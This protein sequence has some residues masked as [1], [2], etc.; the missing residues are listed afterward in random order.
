MREKTEKLYKDPRGKVL[1]SF[2]VDLAFMTFVLLCFTA[3]YETNDDV[4]MSKFVDGQMGE[5]SAFIPFVNIILGF[6]LKGLYSITDSFNWYS[7]AQYLTMFLGFWAIGWVLMKRLRPLPAFTALAAILFT[8]GSNAYLYVNFSKTC[9]VAAAGGLSLMLQSRDPRQQGSRSALILGMALALLG[10]MWR[11]EEFF[12]LGAV[13]APLGLV[14]MGELL[15][16]NKGLDIKNRLFS[17][18][19]Y[20]LP[21]LLLLALVGAC[22]GLD[23]WSWNRGEMKAFFQYSNTRSYLMDNSILPE[24]Q[25]MP[26]LYEELGINETASEMLKDWNFFD[27]EVFSQQQ[28]EALRQSRDERVAKPSAGECLG[29]FLDKVIPGLAATLAFWAAAL[30]LLLWLACGRRR[31]Y[32]WMG[33][34]GSF[35]MFGLVYLFMI[36]QNRYLANRVDMGLLLA[37][38]LVMAFLLDEEKLKN[39]RLFCALLMALAVFVG[40]YKNKNICPY[41]DQYTVEDKSFQKAAVERI[42]EDEEHLYLCKVWSMDH[43]IYGPLEKAPKGFADRIVLSG[44]WSM[45]HPSITHVLQSW[46]I[47]NPYEDM[48]GNEGVYLIDKD[49]EQTLDYIHAYYDEDARAVEVQPLSQETGLKIYS[50]LD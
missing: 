27:T 49:I 11:I 17:L 10:F 9:A 47:V 20:A 30:M 5:K 31:W 32:C 12:A 23:L 34:G 28:M 41:T 46:G 48:I 43:Q 33:L 6:A 50:I 35:A 38:A 1:L 21:F 18:L 37:L 25:E 14:A 29:L 42:L 2:A 16:E 7:F 15:A 3:R 39:D 4:L 45:Y 40:L 24:Y 36:F 44:G 19:R 26:E 8:V 22:I 13:M